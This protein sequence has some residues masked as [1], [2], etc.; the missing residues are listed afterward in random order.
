MRGGEIETKLGEA[1]QRQWNFTTII[2][3]RRKIIS[4]NILQIRLL[5]KN[6]SNKRHWLKQMLT[7][8]ENLGWKF[9]E[10]NYTH[11]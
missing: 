4:E 9:L 2:N 7:D 8:L 5:L 10:A 3:F 11:N 1:W 6:M